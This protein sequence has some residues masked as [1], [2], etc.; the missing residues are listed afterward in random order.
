[1]NTIHDLMAALGETLINTQ[2]RLNREWLEEQADYLLALE[3]SPR[4]P[5]TQPALEPQLPQFQ[6]MT[7]SVALE[8]SVRREQE[9]A[10]DLVLLGQPV[11]RFYE[12]R[13]AQ[14]QSTRT[15]FSLELRAD[16]HLSDP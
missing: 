2:T 11:S 4:H 1:M 13:F 12:R 16:R 8:T 3:N 14:T 6:S 15:Q 7:V 9:T 10:V 5:L